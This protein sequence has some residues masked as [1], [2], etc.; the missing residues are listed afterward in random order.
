[1]HQFEFVSSTGPGRKMPM[2]VLPS[3]SKSNGV[4]SGIV[5]VAPLAQKP[6]I[7]EKFAPVEVVPA[8]HSSPMR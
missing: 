2:S 6:L 4:R 7:I 5:R 3:P 1:M 8:S